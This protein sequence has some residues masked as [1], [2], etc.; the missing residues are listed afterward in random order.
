MKRLSIRSLLAALIV[1][2]LVAF[3]V[4]KFKFP[5]VPAVAHTIARGELVAEFMGTGT[6][7]KFV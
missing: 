5:P 2:A 6:L 1:A 3:A 4:Y 7:V